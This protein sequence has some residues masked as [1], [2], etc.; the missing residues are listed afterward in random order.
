MIQVCVPLLGVGR[1]DSIGLHG[2]Y[3]GR[4]QELQVLVCDCPAVQLDAGHVDLSAGRVVR[5][6]CH[7]IQELLAFADGDV[8]L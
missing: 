4:W 7:S 6:I 5:R 2:P 1:F 8:Y 3:H